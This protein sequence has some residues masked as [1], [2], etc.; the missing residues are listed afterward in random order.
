MLKGNY[1][2]VTYN[3][4]IFSHDYIQEILEMVSVL[5]DYTL[6]LNRR[7]YLEERRLEFKDKTP[8]FFLEN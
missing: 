3:A 1:L 7:F 8:I 2:A 4:F 6:K 5:G